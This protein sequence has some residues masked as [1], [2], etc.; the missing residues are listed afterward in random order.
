[1]TAEG[2]GSASGLDSAGAVAFVTFMT[3]CG[4]QESQ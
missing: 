3:G 4:P 2:E 1:M